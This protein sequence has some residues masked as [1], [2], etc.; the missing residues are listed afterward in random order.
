MLEM[1]LIIKDARPGSSNLYRVLD[2][3]KGES[4]LP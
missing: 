2:I 4:S 1:G 3:P